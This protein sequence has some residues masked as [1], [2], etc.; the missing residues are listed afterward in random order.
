MYMNVTN[1][2][3]PHIVRPNLYKMSK[4]RYICRDSSQI[5]GCQ[6]YE[7]EKEGSGK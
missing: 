3:V 4:I 1:H 6:G 2:I 5:G 7:R